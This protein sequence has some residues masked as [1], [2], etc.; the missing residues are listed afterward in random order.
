MAELARPTFVDAASLAAVLDRTTPEH[1][2]AGEMWR[3]AIDS[4]STLLTTDGTVIKAALELQAK[5]G[6]PAAERFFHDVFPALRVERWREADMTV[7]VASLLA[8]GDPT[9]DLVEHIEETVRTRL[10]IGQTLVGS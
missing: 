5:Y 3:M 9:R 7:A 6:L 1:F 10:R 8:A 2:I 4:R